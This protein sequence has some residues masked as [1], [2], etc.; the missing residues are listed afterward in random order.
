MEDPLLSNGGDLEEGGNHDLE[1]NCN[2]WD[3]MTFKFIS[4]VMNQGVLKQLDSDDLLPL[5]PDM[6][7][8]FCH[9]IILNSWRAQVSNNSL[10]PSL[11]SAL[12]NAYGWPYLCL[13]LLK[14]INDGIGFAGPL[15]L[16]KLIKFLQQG[17]ASWDG[18]LLALSLGLTSI[19]KSFLDTQYTFRLSKLKLKLRSSIMTLIYEKV[20]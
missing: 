19:I 2:F 4:P 6:G 14:V 20:C 18:Y 7:P 16:N 11:F 9:D 1:N 5:L 10:N 3:F 15:L 17:S 8:S 13:G 12:C